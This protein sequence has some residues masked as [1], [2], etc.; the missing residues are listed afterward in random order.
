MKMNFKNMNKNKVISIAISCLL[1]ISLIGTSL[2]TIR[3][4]VNE[5]KTINDINQMI[6]DITNFTDEYNYLVNDDRYM[7]EKEVDYRYL[8]DDID[9]IIEEINDYELVKFK[10]NEEY[11]EVLELMEEMANNLY[12]ASYNHYKYCQTYDSDYGDKA[13]DYTYDTSKSLKDLNKLVKNVNENL[14]EII[15]QGDYKAL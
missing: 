7:F 10:D 6:E 5:E 1:V 9:D 3:N 12:N 4:Q 14:K 8:A 13:D 11:K 15:L 2:I